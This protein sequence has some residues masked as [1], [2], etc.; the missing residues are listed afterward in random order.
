[1]YS[2]ADNITRALVQLVPSSRQLSAF[3]HINIIGS[4]HSVFHSSQCVCVLQILVTRLSVWSARASVRLYIFVCT[5][6]GSIRI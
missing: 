6:S 5:P 1:M 4:G 3:Y 2:P